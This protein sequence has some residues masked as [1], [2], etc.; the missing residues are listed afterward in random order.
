MKQRQGSAALIVFMVIV[1]ALIIGGVWY[2]E[3]NKSA[4][5]APIIQTTQSTQT[6]TNM[7][8]GF[9]FQ[10][11]QGWQVGVSNQSPPEYP[12]FGV[13][14]DNPTDQEN[15]F[16][17]EATSSPYATLDGYIAAEQNKLALNPNTSSWVVKEF[18]LLNIGT[19]AGTFYPSGTVAEN[20]SEAQDGSVVLI[21]NGMMYIL[22]DYRSWQQSNPA[23]Y[24]IA[25]TLSFFTPSSATSTSGLKTYT[26]QQYGF[27]FQYPSSWNLVENSDGTG[28]TVNDNTMVTLG[29]GTPTSSLVISVKALNDSA[30]DT[31]A[32][33]ENPFEVQYDASRNAL[34]DV[35][36]NPSRCLSVEYSLGTLETTSTTVPVILYRDNGLMSLQ[37]VS[38]YA[39]LTNKG[40]MILI[41]I[42]KDSEDSPSVDPAQ[43]IQM[44]HFEAELYSS[45]KLINGV[46]AVVPSC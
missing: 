9:S 29:A 5:T 6:Y 44:S 11:P 35:S 10:Y 23:A 43:Y 17:I 37:L 19:V 33:D 7:E 38:D 26:N 46:Q 14:D 12:T 24:Q 39:V 28:V 25:N 21:K 4:P 22:D 2:Y 42:T 34:M 16:R 8:Y 32:S 1:V 36:D 20:T 30:A 3:A 45:F 18:S 31:I 27:T 15:S 40:Y 13:N 41:N